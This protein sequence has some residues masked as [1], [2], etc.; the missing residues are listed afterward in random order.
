MLALSATWTWPHIW[1]PE[2]HEV[3]GHK[4]DYV[5]SSNG[6]V[7]LHTLF[8]D[9]GAA[10][11]WLRDLEGGSRPFMVHPEHD[12]KCDPFWLD[13][14]LIDEE[15][16]DFLVPSRWKSSDWR[17]RVIREC[18]NEESGKPQ[19]RRSPLKSRRDFTHV[20]PRFDPQVPVKDS[21]APKLRD[22]VKRLLL[23]SVHGSVVRPKVYPHH[24][25]T[26][27]A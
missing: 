9:D 19:A 27:M 14:G 5:V 11:T 7:T 6:P 24:F 4:D 25:E 22:G 2:G 3:I 20:L 21:S 12:K 13:Y 15:S 17:P 10:V 26:R 23:L 18:K 16:D 8:Y 1:N